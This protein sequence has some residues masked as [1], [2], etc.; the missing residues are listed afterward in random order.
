MVGPLGL[1]GWFA[2]YV[3]LVPCLCIAVEHDLVREVYELL[4]AAVVALY[5][6]RP[7]H[8]SDSGAG[9]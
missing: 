8:H 6:G 9:M 7:S 4:P 3:V 1:F 5:T 2:S